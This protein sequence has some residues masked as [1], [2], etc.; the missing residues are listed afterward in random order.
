VPALGEWYLVGRDR[1][2][3]GFLASWRAE[4][5]AIQRWQL[6][7]A[8]LYATASD[9][10]GMVFAAGAG[11]FA[12]RKK[13]AH[14]VLERVFSHRDITAM[15]ADPAGSVWAATTGRILHRPPLV[16]PADWSPVWSDHA[17]TG[18]FIS[19]AALAGMIMAAA[20]DGSIVV[21]HQGLG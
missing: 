12:F 1:A 6:E 17:H 7:S 19:V 21:G 15:A 18:R 16:G 13:E 8:P 10:N 5:G 2:G 3:R 4:T 11:G 9:A 14:P 20:D